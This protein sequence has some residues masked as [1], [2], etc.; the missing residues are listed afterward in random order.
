MDKYIAGFPEQ[1]HEA[2]R[3]VDAATGLNFS[4]RPT[5][6]IISGM[7]GSGIGG[8]LVRTLVSKQL[9]VPYA[10]VNNY[11]L[12]AW[13]GPGT[14]VICSSYSGNTEETL[15]SLA[16]AQAKGC[17]IAC[18][19]TGGKLLE[20]ARQNGYPVITVPPGRPPRS[21]VGYSIVGQLSLLEAAGVIDSAW[22]NIISS[23]AQWLAEQSESLR[24]AAYTLAGKIGDT[25][26]ILYTDALFNAVGVRW[27]QQINENAKMHCFHHV[28]PEMNH[29]ELVA[30][31]KKDDRFS[32]IFIR[33]SFEHPQLKKRFQYTAEL[34]SGKTGYITTV[35]ATGDN[36]YQQ[37]FGMLHFGD[38]IS[39][40]LAE[41][42]R[43]DPIDIAILDR[44]KSAL[45]S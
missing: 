10:V 7:G 32:V 11:A 3:I 15:T 9:T 19:T 44:L 22:R 39:V 13:A 42:N 30:Y 38:W 45:G 27:K 26:P 29:N 23:T 1:L 21:S 37:I 41:R 40:A 8:I 17:S 16:D 24:E 6:V 35:Q 12:P 18:V 5:S 28:I 4:Q 25:I 34:M 20:I 31:D 36:P 33:N 43:V 14:L 2:L